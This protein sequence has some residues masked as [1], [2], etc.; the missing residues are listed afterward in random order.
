MQNDLIP[1]NLRGFPWISNSVWNIAK[2]FILNKMLKSPLIVH[3][4]KKSVWNW[5]IYYTSDSKRY[6]VTV[7]NRRINGSTAIN[8][9]NKV[10][11]R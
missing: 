4:I 8:V 1:T 7:K 3:N 9:N 10:R 5:V 2:E 6:T 11:V